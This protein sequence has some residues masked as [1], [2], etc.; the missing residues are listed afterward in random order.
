MNFKHFFITRFNL[1]IENGRT[2]KNG[3]EVNSSDWLE[4]RCEIFEKYCLPSFLA[5]TQK[6]FIWCLY[7]DPDTPEA[8]IEKYSQYNFIRIIKTENLNAPETND[9]L[10]HLRL[11]TES[12]DI[13]RIITSRVDNDDS[14]NKRYVEAVQHYAKNI[15]LTEKKVINFN[16][17][18][19]YVSDG[20]YVRYIEMGNTYTNPFISFVEPYNNNKYLSVYD[21]KHGAM[22][23]YSVEYVYSEPMWMRI[24]HDRN[25][26]NSQ[27]N[28][29]PR[30][31]VDK[32]KITSENAGFS[33]LKNQ[34]NSNL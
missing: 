21:K 8:I 11:I 16:R 30:P 19:D 12:D 33:F 7:F 27:Y 6:N 3:Q 1:K 20:D 31:L 9:V 32:G 22:K 10:G 34:I 2:D 17:G 4:H 29:G 24:I 5:Q 26:L 25:L 14:I 13:D 18:F 28:Y 23:E 15:P